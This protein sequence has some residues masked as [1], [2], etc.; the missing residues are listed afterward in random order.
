MLTEKDIVILTIT[1]NRVFTLGGTIDKIIETDD[2]K[3]TTH[4]TSDHFGCMVFRDG[5]FHHSLFTGGSAPGTLTLNE[6]R[7]KLLRR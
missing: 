4:I 6:E 1:T 7:M 3:E 5:K 2:G